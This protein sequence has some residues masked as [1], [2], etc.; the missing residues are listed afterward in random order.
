MAEAVWKQAHRRALSETLELVRLDKPTRALLTL[1][2]PLIA[3]AVAWSMLGRLVLATLAAL[4]ASLAIGLLIYLGKL[5]LMPARIALE[6][7][8]EIDRLRADR[9]SAESRRRHHLMGRL[10]HLYLLSHDGI[11][12]AL[13]A[14]LELPPLDWLNE[15]LAI[16]GEN[17][18][19]HEIRGTDYSTFEVIR[20][21]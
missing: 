12:P 15:Q 9:T 1:G 13:A 10:T 8:A 16:Q 20:P 3:I 6:Q 18:S 14:G 4:V 2:V 5:V 19:I 11:P 7:Q 21:A 17:W